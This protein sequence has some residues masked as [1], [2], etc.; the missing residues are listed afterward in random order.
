MVDQH[1]LALVDGELAVRKLLRERLE[2]RVVH[3]KKVMEGVQDVVD[4]AALLGRVLDGVVLRDEG[5]RTRVEGADVAR[6]VVDVQEGDA[7]A[8]GVGGCLGRRRRHCLESRTDEFHFHCHHR[9]H[10]FHHHYPL[11]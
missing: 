10:H 3:A 1:A 6:V 7:R 8:A 2:L 5:R 4:D 11:L 9:Y